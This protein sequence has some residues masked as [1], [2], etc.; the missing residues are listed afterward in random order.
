MFQKIKLY[1]EDAFE[2]IPHS[3]QS[4]E[5]KEE[6]YANLIEKYNDQIEKGIS[7]QE[8]YNIAV[9]SIGDIGELLHDLKP[10][11]QNYDFRPIS[12]GQLKKRATLS[13]LSVA[14]FILSPAILIFFD[15]INSSFG[16]VFMFVAIAGGVSI[17]VYIKNFFPKVS[18][19]YLKSF[20]PKSKQEIKEQQ[21]LSV[22][23]STIWSLA[24]VA[25]IGLSFVFNWWNSSWIIFIVAFALDNIAKSIMMLRRENIDDEQKY[26]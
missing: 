21:I 7:E 6:I 20:Y 17:Q 4:F 14:L 18:G 8:A 19:R 10:V 11:T 12:G 13:A 16:I 9:S 15:V 24:F 25:F 5:L 26:N 1:I 22:V 3:R 2:G 23:S